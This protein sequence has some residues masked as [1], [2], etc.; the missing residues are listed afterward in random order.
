MFADLTGYRGAEIRPFKKS[1]LSAEGVSV[2][3]A[4]RNKGER[5]VQKLREWSPL[6]RCVLARALAGRHE[7]LD[8]QS[9]P[10]HH[11]NRLRDQPSAVLRTAGRA[12]YGDNRQTEPA[13]T[14]RLRLRSPH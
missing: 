1:E 13:S 4:K 14:G 10:E 5:V 12:P 9:R 8:S 6:P 2:I 11:G 7:R 3:S